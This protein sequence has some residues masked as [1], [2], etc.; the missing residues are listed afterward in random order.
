MSV[1][2]VP[3]YH[4]QTRLCGPPMPKSTP[5]QTMPTP[6][7]EIS[8]T[9]NLKSSCV[10]PAAPSSL[11]SKSAPVSARPLGVAVRLASVPEPTPGT[12]TV[13]APV[14]VSWK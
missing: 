7:S 13:S 8:G 10:K 6:A 5:P 9:D 4:C 11:I 3:A 14:A 12:L 1:L 2:A